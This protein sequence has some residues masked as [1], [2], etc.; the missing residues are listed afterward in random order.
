MLAALRPSSG[1]EINHTPKIGLF[2]QV[3]Y[4]WP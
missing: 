2:P 3:N 4:E 1:R